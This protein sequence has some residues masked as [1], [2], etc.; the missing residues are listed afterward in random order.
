MSQAIGNKNKISEEA[1]REATKK[2]YH[3]KNVGMGKVLHEAQLKASTHAKNVGMGALLKGKAK[4]Q[5][6]K[7]VALNEN[8]ENITAKMSELKLGG[9]RRKTRKMKRKAKKTRKH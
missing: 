7:N 9:R 1:Q 8:I 4:E 2:E 3:Q 6:E 5:A